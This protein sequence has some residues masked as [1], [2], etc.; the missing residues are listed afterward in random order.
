MSE[1]S[2]SRD[3]SSAEKDL[4]EN[5][6]SVMIAGEGKVLTLRTVIS[7]PLYECADNYRWVLIFII[8]VNRTTSRGEYSRGV[9]VGSEHLKRIRLKK[10]DRQLFPAGTVCIASV[11]VKP[12]AVGSRPVYVPFPVGG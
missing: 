2:R 9:F 4:T 3:R 11:A 6:S 8:I 7:A 10:N 5:I 12:R 1:S